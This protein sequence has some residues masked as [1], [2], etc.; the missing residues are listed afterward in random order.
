MKT[1]VQALAPLFLFLALILGSC[2]DECDD[3]NCQNGGRCDDG[4]CICLDG[5]VGN[6]CQSEMRAPFLGAYSVNEN[7]EGGNDTFQMTITTSNTGV[8]NIILVFPGL[9]VAAE[10]NGASMT[11]P[12][13][14]INVDNTALSISGTGQLTGNILTMSYTLGAGGGSTSCSATCTK[15]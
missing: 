8:R 3:V 2:S 1:T 12:N 9:N 13:Q 5:F 14:T 10:V 6:E 7:C 11:I 15:L 4:D